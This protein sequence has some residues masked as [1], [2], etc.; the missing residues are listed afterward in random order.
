MTF[1]YNKCYSA[2]C[3]SQKVSK[4][5]YRLCEKDKPE[6]ENPPHKDPLRHKNIPVNVSSFYKFMC[7]KFPAVE[8]L[9]V[10]WRLM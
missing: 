4:N 8:N 3:K 7:T 10:E 1:K 2:A 6:V 5:T 9:K